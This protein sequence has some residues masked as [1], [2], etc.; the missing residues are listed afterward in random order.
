[1]PPR[2]STNATNGPRMPAIGT[3]ML[4]NPAATPASPKTNS[5]CA[6]CAMKM[7]PIPVPPRSAISP[8]FHQLNATVLS[9][10][11]VSAIVGDRLLL[12]EPRSLQPACPDTLSSEGC[13][14]RS[15]AGIRQTLVVV[16][17]A[18]II[19]VAFD[20]KSE[21]RASLEQLDHLLDD[22]SRIRSYVGLVEIK[23]DVE[24]HVA[25]GIELALHLLG[26][27][28]RR[29]RL[30]S[31]LLYDGE[32]MVRSLAR[33][34]TDVGLDPDFA[35]RRA[36]HVNASPIGGESMAVALV[37]VPRQVTLEMSRV[38]TLVHPHTAQARHQR[39]V[40]FQD[41]ERRRSRPFG[42]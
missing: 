22:R 7:A 42:R 14:H 21:I 10:P 15:C 2:N 6:P 30:H 38:S 18:D 39:L 33:N 23:V 19:S 34:V 8:G 11:R 12:P 26:R 13:D 24:R 35:S 9:P 3:P 16:G 1:M 17:C 28:Q 27:K 20:C 31:F 25:L 4:A 29:P 41:L 37:R 5:F 36:E 40:R 32:V